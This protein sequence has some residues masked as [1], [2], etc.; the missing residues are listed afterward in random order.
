MNKGLDRETVSE[1]DL[2]VNAIDMNEDNRQ[3]TAVSKICNRIM[4]KCYVHLF[5]LSKRILEKNLL[6]HNPMVW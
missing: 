2:I 3:V 6:T 5:N 4:S 1:Y